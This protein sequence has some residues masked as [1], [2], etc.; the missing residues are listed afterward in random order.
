MHSLE[1]KKSVQRHHAAFILDTLEDD[2]SI[3]C[4]EPEDWVEICLCMAPGYET[5]PS[6]V[7]SI[8]LTTT[9]AL[10]AALPDAR[11]PRT[12]RLCRFQC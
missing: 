6:H 4:I 2:P 7:A 12:N 11:S 3:P 10:F 1:L 9:T 8:A 5:F